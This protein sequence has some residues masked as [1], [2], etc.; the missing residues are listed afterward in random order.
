MSKSK[1]DIGPLL[2]EQKNLTSN[3]KEMSNILAELYAKV[4][5]T[6]ITNVT[7]NT[8]FQGE[9][10]YRKLSITEEDLIK[11][12]NELSPSAAK[13]PDN[14]PA[15][16]LKNCK[17]EL[18]EPLL[19]LWKTSFHEGTVPSKLKKCMITP[20]HKGGSKAEAAN[21]RPIALTSHIIKIF[22][23]VLRNHL[24]NYMDENS[25]FNPNQHGFRKGHSCLSELLDHYDNIL[26]FLNNNMNVDVIYL[27]FA[28][29]FDKVNYGVVLQK[30]K[31]LGV[32]DE[33]L[34]WLTSFLTGRNQTVVVNGHSSD[35]KLVISGVPQGSVLGPLIFQILLA[36]VEKR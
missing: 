16:L 30:I 33:T 24:T 12:I 26:D 34:K 9:K 4:F 23:K 14:F 1:S 25:L 31:C 20:S 27:D 3:S 11:A 21:Y 19:K 22:E 28:K 13:G 15:L 35:P 6:P 5:S 2:N 7:S 8:V 36:D 18:I 32:D 17:E 10:P 29:A